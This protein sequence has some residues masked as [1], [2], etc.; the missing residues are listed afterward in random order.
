ML[1]IDG[2]KFSA[3]QIADFLSYG[4]KPRNPISAE[5]QVDSGTN[6]NVDLHVDLPVKGHLPRLRCPIGRN[7][8]RSRNPSLQRRHA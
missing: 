6:Q 2:S 5:T 3:E 4:I 7:V 8:P 1:E